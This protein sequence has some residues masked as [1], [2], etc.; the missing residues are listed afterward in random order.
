MASRSIIDRST[1]ETFVPEI[2]MSVTSEFTADWQTGLLDNHSRK[3][4][5][6]LHRAANCG[7]DCIDA[8]DAHFDYDYH[9]S[10]PN[11][12]LTHHEMKD[13]FGP[14]DSAYTDLAEKLAPEH[15]AATLLQLKRVK[16]PGFSRTCNSKRQGVDQHTTAVVSENS[17]AAGTG[18]IPH[19]KVYDDTFC[20]F[21]SR[22]VRVQKRLDEENRVTVF[23]VDWWATPDMSASNIDT[24]NNTPTGFTQS[25]RGGASV[26]GSY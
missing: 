8:P 21:G 11:V 20:P 26:P 23:T 12:R 10:R 14:E 7:Q 9:L 4:T 6:R 1:R 19:Q 16:P 13:Y 22:A 2:A 18:V 24:F 5:S 3:T 15:L 25:Y 17:E